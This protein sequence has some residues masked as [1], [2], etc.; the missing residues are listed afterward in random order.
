ML[1][2]TK[3]DLFVTYFEWVLYPPGPIP[4][5]LGQLANLKE[6]MLHNNRLTGTLSPLLPSTCV[7]HEERDLLSICPILAVG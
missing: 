5:E 3:V 6:M 2:P 7:E 1:Y 4:A